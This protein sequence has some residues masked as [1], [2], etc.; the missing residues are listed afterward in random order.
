MTPK[1]YFE[2]H[3]DDLILILIGLVALLTF[4]VDALGWFR[5]RMFLR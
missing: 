3:R 5:T 4:L 1:H 2:E